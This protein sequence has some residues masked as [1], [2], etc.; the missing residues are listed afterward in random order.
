MEHRVPRGPCQG[1]LSSRSRPRGTLAGNTLVSQPLFGL[2]QCHPPLPPPQSLAP[3]AGFH[4]MRSAAGR[5]L[6]SHFAPCPRFHYIREVQAWALTAHRQSGHG[7]TALLTS[8]HWPPSPL[9]GWATQFAHSIRCQVYCQGH[10]GQ[11]VARQ[12][13][14]AP[15]WALVGGS[16]VTLSPLHSC[17]GPGKSALA[18]F[19][20]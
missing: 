2:T 7:Q 5:G 11:P 13:E 8:G 15:S 3:M 20:I 14:T 1:P 19:C 12:D 17:P 9:E 18:H 16:P 6:R 10:L 4:R